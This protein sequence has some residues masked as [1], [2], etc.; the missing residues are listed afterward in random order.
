MLL[1]K[2]LKYY[3][4]KLLHKDSYKKGNHNALLYFE[5]TYFWKK[6]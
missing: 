6:L 4:K 2:A 1:M 3:N 5:K